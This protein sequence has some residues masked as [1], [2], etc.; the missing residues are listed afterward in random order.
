MLLD[1]PFCGNTVPTG[2]TTWL[3]RWINAIQRRNDVVCPVG[4]E[5]RGNEGYEGCARQNNQFRE[6][7]SPLIC[8]LAETCTSHTG[9][10]AWSGVVLIFSASAPLVL[11]CFWISPA[12]GHETNI[13]HARPSGFIVGQTRASYDY[14]VLRFESTWDHM[15]TI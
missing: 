8:G 7:P 3:W 5:R 10:Q 6:L 11:V 15:S 9:V 2:H 14:N 4:C 13:N 12:T 1:H